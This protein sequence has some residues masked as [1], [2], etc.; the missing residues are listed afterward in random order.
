[1]PDD[2]AGIQLTVLGPTDSVY[3]GRLADFYAY[4]NDLRSCWVRGNMITS[5]DGGAAEDGKSGG[6]GGPGDR[7]IFLQMRE[8]ADV[9]LVG[10]T[11]VRVENYSGAQMSVAARQARQ[12]RG[13]AHGPDRLTV[14]D[15]QHGRVVLDKDVLTLA[16][17]DLR[18]VVFT[19]P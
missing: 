10:A 8:A 15:P 16:S 9:I 4:P 19:T 2:G 13:Q 11:T 6:L 17:G 1:M 5:L 7:A 3:D 14:P 12:R 18:V